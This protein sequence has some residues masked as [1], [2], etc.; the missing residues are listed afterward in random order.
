MSVY[1]L[2]RVRIP[3]VNID[4]RPPRGLWS[5]FYDLK[6]GLEFI[7]LLTS[8]LGYRETVFISSTPVFYERVSLQ[9]FKNEKTPITIR[10]VYDEINS[11]L[12]L[13]FF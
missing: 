2:I 12:L 9:S 3:V 8:T 5:N 6:S 4:G 1:V 13:Y 10:Y 11:V 7:L